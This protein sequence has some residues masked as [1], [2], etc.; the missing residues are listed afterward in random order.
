MLVKGFGVERSGLRVLVH[1]N[2]SSVNQKQN[3]LE[4]D[5]VQHRVVQMRYPQ[6]LSD[7]TSFTQPLYQRKHRA[8]AD[9]QLCEVYVTGVYRPRWDRQRVAEH[10]IFEDLNASSFNRRRTIVLLKPTGIF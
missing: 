5:N 8:L 9:H 3:I 4:L 2:V 1:K 7:L 10:R 6:G